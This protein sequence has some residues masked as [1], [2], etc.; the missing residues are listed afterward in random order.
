VRR[1]KVIGKP[2]PRL[3][4]PDTVTGKAAYTVD[5]GLPAMLHGKL[6]RSSVPH[7]KIR[8]LDVSRARELSGVAAVLTAEPGRAWAR[9]PQKNWVFP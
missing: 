3:D 6:F 7:A 1:F 4:G 9:S 8:H 5:V 2:Y